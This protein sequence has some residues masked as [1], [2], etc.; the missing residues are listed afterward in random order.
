MSRRVDER[1]DR[2]LLE[3]VWSGDRDA[4]TEFAWRHAKWAADYARRQGAG[5]YADDVAQTVLSNLLARP[6]IGL[7]DNSAKPYLS[8]CITREISKEDTARI[9]AHR[10]VE[11]PRDYVSSPSSAIAR[12]EAI[13][14]AVEELPTEKRQLL[15]LRFVGGLSHA[16]IAET[17]GR[18]AGSVRSTMSRLLGSIRTQFSA[19]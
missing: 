5:D 14:L 17:T 1:T 19:D 10:G 7:R 9:R 4:G 18:P 15:E 13:A 11:M 8:V 2:E 16:E 6:K 12:R 3:A